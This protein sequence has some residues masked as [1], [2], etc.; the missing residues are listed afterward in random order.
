MPA[1]LKLVC[2]CTL[3][4][5]VIRKS[6][7]RAKCHVIVTWEVLQAFLCIATIFA[8]NIPNV[9]QVMDLLVTHGLQP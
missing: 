5:N 7:V 3:M 9:W 2:M 4:Y 1:Q 6:Q 8:V